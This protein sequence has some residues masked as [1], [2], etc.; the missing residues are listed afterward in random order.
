M[1][2]EGIA[3]F[4]QSLSHIQ[5]FARPRTAACQAPLSFAISQS[6]LK[7]MFIES[8]MPSNHLILCGPLLLLPSVFPSI[9]PRG[10]SYSNASDQGQLAA[11]GFYLQIETQDLTLPWEKAIAV[12]LFMLIYSFLEFAVSEII[13]PFLLYILL[14]AIFSLQAGLFAVFSKILPEVCVAG[15]SMVLLMNPNVLLPPGPLAYCSRLGHSCM[16]S[17]LP[18]S[19]LSTLTTRGQSRR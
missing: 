8:M 12:Q 1:S 2:H 7:L 3:V 6:L 13:S 17:T 15:L 19:C 18:D 10:H 16:S 9:S 11:A 14:L 5:P 4:V